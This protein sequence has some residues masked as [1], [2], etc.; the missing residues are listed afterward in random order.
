LCGSC[1]SPEYFMGLLIVD[2]QPWPN[3]KRL[4]PFSLCAGH[5]AQRHTTESRR[6]NS[7]A[8]RTG[9]IPGPEKPPWT[10]P[11]CGRSPGGPKTVQGPAGR[12][13]H[14]W[15][16]NGYQLRHF[17]FEPCWI[18]TRNTAYSSCTGSSDRSI[19][20]RLNLTYRCR[21]FVSLTMGSEAYT[22]KWA[23]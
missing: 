21:A 20:F 6:A 1:V 5:G 3:Q 10:G 15:W 19:T 11:R 23:V 14:K 17:N 12:S 16:C 7:E 4:Q 2:G 9:A 22:V 8:P 18:L 13:M